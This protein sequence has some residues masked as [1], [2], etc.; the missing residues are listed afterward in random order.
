MDQLQALAAKQF[1]NLALLLQVRKQVYSGAQQHHQTVQK[2][3][4]PS[5]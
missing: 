4:P 2:V 5:S 1:V 3:S